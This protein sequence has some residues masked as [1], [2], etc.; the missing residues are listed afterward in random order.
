MKKGSVK[1]VE[2]KKVATKTKTGIKAKPSVRPTT[3]KEKAKRSVNP[4]PV[5]NEVDEVADSFKKLLSKKSEDRAKE[6]EELEKI[7]AEQRNYTKQAM[8]GSQVTKQRD[9]CIKKLGK[10]NYEK[11]YEHFKKAQEGK[12]SFKTL[13][14]DIEQLIGKANM[15][16]AFIIDQI[17]VTDMFKGDK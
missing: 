4:P 9:D 3:T 17:V 15:D 5:N 6:G 7:E 10:E 2:V 11:V 14:Q 1:K 8:F 12:V 13:T 16:T